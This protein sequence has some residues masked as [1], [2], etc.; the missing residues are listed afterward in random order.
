MKRVF[1]LFVTSILMTTGAITAQET[2]NAFKYKVGNYEVILL[3]EGQNQGNPGILI[4]ATPEMLQETM[5][6]GSY[7]TAVNAFLV[8]TPNHNYLI[9]TGFGRNL[10]DNLKAF[11]VAPENVNTL[12]LTHMHGD[13]I[14]GM[15]KDGKN[16]FPNAKVQLSDVEHTYWTSDAE[17]NK[18]PEDRRKSF[19]GPRN[20]LKAYAN[21]IELVK[22]EE[23]GEKSGN[24]IFFIKA[25]GHTPGHIGCLVKSGNEQLL[26]WADLAHAMA[27]QM[28]YPQ[29]AVTYDTYPDMAVKS[30]K[31]ILEYVSKH[32]IPIAGMHIP[33]PSIGHVK[34]NGKG[35]YVFSPAN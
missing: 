31:K 10:P 34:A 28:P 25:Y 17:M 19:Q 23:I 14:G 32:N 33:Y 18:L 9:D 16:V 12:I 11:N 27:I 2:K 21:K 5:P 35:G 7:P 30:R 24:G 20:A 13:H 1:I 8:K 4:G 29:I 26:I 3:S 15:I 6:N 22:A